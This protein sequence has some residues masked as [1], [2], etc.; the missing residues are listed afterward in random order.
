MPKVKTFY[1]F[2]FLNS[3]ERSETI[4]LG[5]LG[6]LG[7]LDIFFLLMHYLVLETIFSLSG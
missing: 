5:I 6:N 4:I 3:T 1:R 2:K 7:I